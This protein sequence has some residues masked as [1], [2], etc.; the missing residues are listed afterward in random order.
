M[1]FSPD[2]LPPLLASWR[3]EPSANPGFRRAVRERL[4]AGV[5]G[6]TWAAFA[7]RRA[8]LVAGAFAVALIGGAV[9]GHD[10]ARARVDEDRARL[11][12]AYVAGLDARLMVPA[13]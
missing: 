10:R 1:S 4:G 8:P 11:A 9:G 12:S 6:A 5:A 2:P 13:R 3:V 7:R